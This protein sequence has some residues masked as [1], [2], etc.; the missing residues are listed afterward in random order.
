MSVY[1]NLPKYKCEN[2][3]KFS[4]IATKCGKDIIVGCACK[5]LCDRLEKLE[6]REGRN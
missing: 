3:D 4:P 6:K 5:K 1:L 2:C